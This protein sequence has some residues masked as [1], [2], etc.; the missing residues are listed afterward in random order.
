[1]KQQ[2]PGERQS[3]RAD[4]ERGGNQHRREQR[5]GKPA[6]QLAHDELV[7]RHPALTPELQQGV[8]HREHQRDAA[9]EREARQEQP[10]EADEVVESCRTDPGRVLENGGGSGHA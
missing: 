4:P 10:A 9:P 1:M 8:L 2:H 7:E 3:G 5:A 6:R